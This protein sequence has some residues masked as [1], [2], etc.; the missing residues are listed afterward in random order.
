MNVV[1][2]YPNSYSRSL[3]PIYGLPK[4]PGYWWQTFRQCHLQ[5]LETKKCFGP[6]LFFKKDDSNNLIGVVRTL[7][8][9]M[10]EAENN[11]LAI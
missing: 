6:L 4:S 10:L 8:D 7:V 1:D 3:K 2:Q 9:D 11:D 5:D